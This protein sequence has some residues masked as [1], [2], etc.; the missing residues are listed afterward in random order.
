VQLARYPGGGA[1][2]ERHRDAF[3]G[4]PSRRLTAIY[5]LND[6]WSPADGGALRIHADDGAVDLA[7][8]IDRLVVFLSERLEHEVLPAFAPRLAI[9]AWYRGAEPLPR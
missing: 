9:T 7:P 2:Y 8:T 4:G 3:S 5:Y 1:R 6:G